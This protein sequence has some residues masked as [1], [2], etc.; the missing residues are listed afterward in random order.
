MKRIVRIF[1]DINETTVMLC[2]GIAV[3]VLGY[4]ATYKEEVDC[5]TIRVLGD[6]TVLDQAIGGGIGGVVATLMA[7]TP[8]LFCRS[9]KSGAALLIGGVL[10][11]VYM[12]ILDLF[13]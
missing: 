1:L 7:C 9:A 2:L 10:F 8:V 11:S 4:F 3:S 13:I 5:I 6:D 12:T